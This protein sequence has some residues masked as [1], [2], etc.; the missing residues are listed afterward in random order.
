MGRLWF[1]W[2]LFANVAVAPLGIDLLLEGVRLRR[3]CGHAEEAQEEESSSSQASTSART[4]A[5]G[6]CGAIAASSHAAADHFRS[7]PIILYGGNS[8]I[9]HAS[10]HSLC[11]SSH[12][13][14]CS[15]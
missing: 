15:T 14:V 2:L 8:S 4:S 11:S 12:H 9:L 7:H 10:H 3:M 6:S 1:L 13:S 5:R